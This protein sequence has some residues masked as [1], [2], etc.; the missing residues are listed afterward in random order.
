MNARIFTR[1]VWI[2]SIVSFLTDISSEMLYPIM[3]L[4]LKSIGF[5]IVL[6]GVLEGFAEAIAGVS[7]GYFGKMSDLT[8]KRVPFVRLGYILSAVSKPMMGLLTY[9]FW[10][11]G[12]R[13]MDRIGKGVRTSA[14]D[15]ILS[16]ESTPENKGKVFGFHRGMD[17][18]GAVLGPLAALIYLGYYP[19]NY[20]T[21]FFLA[22]IPAVIGVAF[23]FI[24]KEKN[25]DYK[26]Y[27]YKTK[28]FS[29]LSYWKES[30]TEYKKL[31]AG[32]FAFTL[33]NSSDIFLLLM[34][35]NIGYSDKEV[36]MVYI[37]YNLVY[38]LSS[39]PIGIIADKT[40]L[41]IN[42]IFGLIIFAVVYGSMAANPGI[43]FVYFIF[44][45]YGI[46]AASTEGISKA[47]ITN[48]SG[49]KDTATAIGFYTGLNSLFSLLA[50]VIAG[51][52]W[53]SFSPKVM[54]VFSSAGAVL[55]VI[56]FIAVFRKN[57]GKSV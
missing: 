41:K 50:S 47:W 19:E 13:T 57:L 2:V 6:I 1:A 9:P 5:S 39:L 25:R 24:L 56:Y 49:K 29:F 27:D 16:D 52:L 51:L 15:A 23:T 4:Y 30:G 33:I 20:R 54:F 12:A 10:I 21:L 32:L 3:P 45:L 11:F 43:E 40:G 17:T 7:K 8:G 42:Y 53:Y 36:I 28:F 26:K 31:V 38:A 48:I 34:V 35:K 44:F 46:Y 14:R 37:F 18:L 22:F 55:V